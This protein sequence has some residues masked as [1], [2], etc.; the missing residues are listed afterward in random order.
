MS[1]FTLDQTSCVGPKNYIV[2]QHVHLYTGSDQQCWTQELYCV[3]ACP[4]L[5]RIRPA[6]LD[7]RT[8]LCDSMSI[9]TPHQ[10]SNVGPK[11]YIVWQH[12]HLDTGSDPISKS[13]DS[14]FICLL[15]QTGRFGPMKYKCCPCT[16]M[17]QQCLTQELCCV[18]AFWPAHWFSHP[19]ITL[20][21]SIFICPL[22]WSPDH[23]GWTHEPHHGSKHGA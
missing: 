13:C 18:T 8:T 19:R 9:F 1:I 20:W 6:M 3:I 16:G 14:I 4:S 10:T 21:N 11:N 12:V 22:V 5:H 7:P 15:V 17:G 23:L 2:W